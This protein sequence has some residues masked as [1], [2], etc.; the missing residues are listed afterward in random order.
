MH[1][2]ILQHL[3]N[4][5]KN[6]NIQLLIIVHLCDALQSDIIIPIWLFTATLQVVPVTSPHKQFPVSLRRRAAPTA[7]TTVTVKVLCHHWGNAHESK[8]VTEFRIFSV[9]KHKLRSDYFLINPSKSADNL[10][11]HLMMVTLKDFQPKDEFSF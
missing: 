11:K 6:I 10:L 9:S 2:T 5:S 8:T 4:N 3:H 7:V 1:F